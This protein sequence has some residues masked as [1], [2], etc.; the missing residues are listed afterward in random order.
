MKNLI[1]I[2]FLFGFTYSEA[3]NSKCKKVFEK[4]DLPGLYKASKDN[5]ETYKNTRNKR[6]DLEKIALITGH[7][8]FQIE[9]I[10]DMGSALGDA[11]NELAKAYPS[12]QVTGVDLDP[13]MV[14]FANKQ[15]D[16]SNNLNF[17][18][19]DI[20]DKNFENNSLDLIINSAVI[21]HVTSFSGDGYSVIEGVKALVNHFDQ[22]KPQGLLYLR[23]FVIPPGPLNARLKIRNDNAKNHPLDSKKTISTFGLFEIFARDFRSSIHKNSVPYTIIEKTSDWV[24]VESDFRTLVEFML[25]KD[26]VENWSA[27]IQ[28]EYLFMSQKQLNS[29]FTMNN[30]NLIVSRPIY[31]QWVYDNSFKDEVYLMDTEGNA[32]P[33][34]PTKI[35]IVAQKVQQ[36]QAVKIIEKREVHSKKPSYLDVGYWKNKETKEIFQTISRPSPVNDILPYYKKDGKVYIFTRRGHSRGIVNAKTETPHL[37]GVDL[38]GYINEIICTLA[39][40]NKEESIKNALVEKENIID[41]FSGIKKIK[42]LNSYYIIKEKAMPYLVE[43][44]SK[45]IKSQDQLAH[46]DIH[47]SLRAFQVGGSFD[48]RTEINIYRLLHYENMEFGD[49]IGED[50]NLSSLSIDTSQLQKFSFD[51]LPNKKSWE[52]T[53]ETNPYAKIKVSEFSERNS[54]DFE[55]KSEILEHISYNETSH[56][57]LSLLPIFKNKEGEIYVGLEIRDLP[58]PQI[59]DNNSLLPTVPAYRIPKEDNNME[60]AINYSSNQ[61]EENF[62][63]KIRNIHPLGSD[64]YSSSGLSPETVYPFLA[65]VS[66]QKDNKLHWIKIEDL[67]KQQDKIKSAHLLTALFRVSHA[68]QIK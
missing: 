7:L 47:H 34:P 46:A 58:I 9:H 41:D 39:N 17:V 26:Y 1:L 48:T 23:D 24:T 15:H 40:C 14:E 55:L 6:M 8:P 64:Y 35:L 66:P 56:H 27:E 52:K 54:T 2:F 21:H 43:L 19:G 59:L 60:L 28:E 32:L 12:S 49:W 57:A 25:H 38:S 37:R 63:V 51:K 67:L 61:L 62:N 22:L 30:M 29:F 3:S 36:D 4:S 16:Q 31:N 10:V 50:V 42:K 45:K 13:K 20:S 44:D 33:Y 53:K 18:I 65:E 68:L 5:V 11:T